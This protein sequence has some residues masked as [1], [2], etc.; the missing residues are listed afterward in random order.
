MI[1]AGSVAAAVQGLHLK[2]DDAMSS[3][4]LT[5][6]LSQV[7]RSDPVREDNPVSCKNIEIEHIAPKRA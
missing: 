5:Y 3:Q 6:F 4:Q 2:M 1:A 7:I